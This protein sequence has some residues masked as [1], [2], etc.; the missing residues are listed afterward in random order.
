MFIGS[1]G[2][3][4]PRLAIGRPGRT[5]V[6]DSTRRE[7]TCRTLSPCRTSDYRANPV[8]HL[9]HHTSG[10]SD[11]GFL[12]ILPED[13]SIEDAVRALKT[14]QLT[15]PLGARQ[16]YFNLGYVVLAGIV[17]TV[18]GQSYADYIQQHIFAPLQMTHTYTDRRCKPHGLLSVTVALASRCPRAGSL[19]PPRTGAGY[20]HFH[21]E[22][23]ANFATLEQ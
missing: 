1:R 8:A 17:E 7:R 23:L 12:T 20:I 22:T 9:L 4:S 10:L 6:V 18:S 14:A 2:N 13:A 16:Q 19:R 11:A 3:R 15:A 21:A 5:G